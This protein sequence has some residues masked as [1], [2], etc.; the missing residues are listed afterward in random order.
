MV[1]FNE[2]LVTNGKLIIDVSIEDICYY[3][4]MFIEKIKVSDIKEEYKYE[5]KA[6]VVPEVLD[7]ICQSF[8][9]VVPKEKE[10]IEDGNTTSLKRKRIRLELKPSDLKLKNLNEHLFIINVEV[11]GIPDPNTPC[12]MDEKSNIAYTYYAKDWYDKSMNF[13][14]NSSDIDDGFVDFILKKEALDLALNC[15]NLTKA[16]EYFD[17]LK[18]KEAPSNNKAC[19]CNG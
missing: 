12:T 3:E 18:T 14:R 11:G 17:L 13:I 4:N 1:V 19:K 7:S 16:S 2:L 8:F 10:V 15:G 9:G 5:Y 6:T